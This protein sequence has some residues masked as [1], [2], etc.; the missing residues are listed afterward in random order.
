MENRITD[1]EIRIS[2]QES[3]IDELTRTVLLQE[4][5]IRK[6]QHEI[7]TIRNQ[8]KEVSIIAHASE[9]IP[10]PHY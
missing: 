5:H 2:H 7:D 3:S 6:L 8:V 10:P 1:L 4:D 9:E